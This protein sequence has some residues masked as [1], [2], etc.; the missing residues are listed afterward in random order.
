MQRENPTVSLTGELPLPSEI[1]CPYEREYHY[2]VVVCGCGFAGLNAAVS[3]KEKGGS[4]LV[5]DKGRPGYSGL[6]PW[7]GT[8]RWFDWER[9]D[10]DAYRKAI[11]LG[12][13]YISNLN[14][15]D[16]WLR[17]S[18][19]M[20]ERLKNW[21]IL[22]QFPKASE[23]GHFEN[24]DYAGYRE[25]FDQFDRHKKWVKVLERYEIPFLQH[26]M[27]TDVIVD[28]G[29]V[30]GV[31]GFHVPSGQVITVHAKAVVLATGGGCV[32]PAGYPVGGNSFDGEYIAYQLGLPISGKEFEDFHAT[33]S[34]APGNALVDNSWSYLENIWLCGGDINRENA[35]NYAASKGRI[36]VMRRVHDALDGVRSGDGTD[37]FDVS[38]GIF[39][40]RGGS[41]ASLT[42]PADVRTGRKVDPTPAPDIFG[43]ATGLCSH[44]SSGVFCG[45]DDQ[46][47]DT[48][49]PGLFVAGDGIHATSPAGSSYPCG[50][51]FASCFCS[52]DGDHAGKAAAEYARGVAPEEI[53][54]HL[55][56]QKAEE[57]YAP[58]RLEK[59]FDPNWARDALMGIM[60]PYWVSVV[61]EENTLQAALTQVRY[62]R[63]HVVP[64]L[65]ACNGHDL[66]LCIEM[67]HKVLASELKL[68][69]SIERKES[70]GTT[71]RTD[72]PYRD[73]ENFLCYITLQKDANG[74][75]CVGKVPVKDE[76]AGDRTLEYSKRY[77]YYF[78][79]EP[80]AKGFTVEKKTWKGGA[81]A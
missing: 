48:G 26:T 38:K 3:A 78:P 24:E 27:V 23:S 69:A 15:F 53:P 50:V 9:D 45:L 76:W 56:E 42:D 37:I 75:V 57:L 21:G 33:C 41:F 20:Y 1:S 70:R 74:N 4:V 17:E 12:G 28:D 43:S 7:A 61:K 67:K 79:G 80:E 71:Y 5:I 39:T 81:K 6:A 65:S 66:R 22:D 55:I 30:K 68:L 31:M 62:M 59:G 36:M 29:K 58:L 8:F 25:T 63:D 72:Y 54:G 16:T 13:D 40:R 32:R 52:I 46:T 2:D 19:G 49:I 44:L 11:M 77:R 64:K 18:K 14:W 60:A 73:D 51:G 10:V 34:I 47:G 35:E